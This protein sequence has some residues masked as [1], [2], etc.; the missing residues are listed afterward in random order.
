MVGMMEMSC[1]FDTLEW[2]HVAAGRDD[3]REDKELEFDRK[4]HQT[5]DLA[6]TLEPVVCDRRHTTRLE[7]SAVG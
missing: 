4:V 6:I 5:K 1:D 7:D 2:V 3:T